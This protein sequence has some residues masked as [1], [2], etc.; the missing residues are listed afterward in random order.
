MGDDQRPV[1]D[2]L[3]DYDIF[4]PDF[5]V[6]PFPVMDAIRESGC[7]IAHSDRWG[8]SWLPTRYAD[9]VAM[10]QEY[11]VFTSRDVLV[12]PAAPIEFEFDLFPMVA[13]PPI[14]SDPPEHHWHRR[15]VLPF[16]EIGRAHV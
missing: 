12:T 16:F 11:D 8:G 15:L 14:S 1:V 9:V 13:A 4:D 7:P 6:D 10:A 2:P 5:V 3:T